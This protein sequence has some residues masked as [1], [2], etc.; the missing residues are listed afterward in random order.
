MDGR[1]TT[2]RMRY[3]YLSK[4]GVFMLAHDYHGK[5]GLK[6]KHQLRLRRVRVTDAANSSISFPALDPQRRR[7]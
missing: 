1:A 3:S 6:V 5:T 4:D 7:N 2:L